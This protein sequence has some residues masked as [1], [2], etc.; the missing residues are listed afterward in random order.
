MMESL[1]GRWIEPI[2]ARVGTQRICPL[3][4]FLNLATSEQKNDYTYKYIIQEGSTTLIIFSGIKRRR[5]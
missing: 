1:A 4:F 3:G 2:I 5:N